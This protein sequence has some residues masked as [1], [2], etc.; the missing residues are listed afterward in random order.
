MKNFI[1]TLGL[2]FLVIFAGCNRLDDNQATP[3]T[4]N[5]S[6]LVQKQ[7]PVS[8]PTEAMYNRSEL[9]NRVVA[10]QAERHDFHWEWTDMRTLWSA[11][12]QT[13]E[14][15]L[16]YKPAHIE[17]IDPI[18][19]QINLQSKEWRSVHDALLNLVLEG[20]NKNGQTVTL[21]DILI[22]DDTVLP[23]LIL[24]IKDKEVLTQLYNLKNVRY[25]EPYGYWP[26]AWDNRSSSG[27]SG[28]SQALNAADYTTITPG[29]KLPWN[30]NNVNIPAAWASAEGQGIRI[31]VIDAGISSS[32]SLL[33]S[34]FNDGMS[35]VGRNI[36][37][38]YTYGTSAYTSCTHGT[39]MTGLAAGPRNAQNATTGVSYKS[40]LHFIRGCADVVLDASSELTGVKN[41]LKKMGD[42]TDIKIISMSVG[43]PFSSGTLKDGV[44]Y[45]Y[46]KGKLIFAA[47]GTSF[48]WT[49]WWGVIYPAALSQCQAVT[50]VNES[51]STCS[52]CHDGSQVDFTIPM[53]RNANTN[54]SSLS[55][56]P[57]GFNPT[58]IGGSSCA[59]AITAGIAGLIWSVNPMLTRTQIITAMQQTSQ[60]YPNPNSSRGYGNVNAGAAVALAATY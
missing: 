51:S 58:Y 5:E 33:G 8:V 41:A 39:S 30:Y 38:D 57:S 59:T 17:N 48:S 9:D 50:G 19:H 20:L 42:L 49:S 40:S 26:A 29:C 31:G 60:Y 55:L 45:A 18:I 21:N 13:F 34:Q 16:G 10:L 24:R 1:R 56:A 12:N 27:C 46:N 23:I 11:A 35:N 52:D 25:L 28:S 15:A 7:N 32:Q 37:T 36:T 54:R 2:L 6:V 3:T 53:E 22:E 44:T 14:V 43:T 47:T 4:A